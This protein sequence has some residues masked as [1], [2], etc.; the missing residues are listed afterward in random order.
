ME[1]FGSKDGRISLI[2]TI[3][4]GRKIAFLSVYSPNQFDLEF[5]QDLSE[6]L[7]DM[8][9]FSYVIGSDMNSIIN[10]DLDCSNPYDQCSHS[11]ILASN[12]LSHM[13]TLNN[14]RVI[15]PITRQYSFFSHR[16]KSYS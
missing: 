5:F 2:K 15:K 13:T 9:D 3:I 14:F 1:K 12:A 10:G 11:Q 7:A 16:H 6:L 8:N 4:A